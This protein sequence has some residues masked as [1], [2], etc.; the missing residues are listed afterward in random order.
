MPFPPMYVFAYG[1]PAV[2]EPPPHHLYRLNSSPRSSST[3]TKRPSWRGSQV[4][5]ATG[6]GGSTCLV[7]RRVYTGGQHL[8]HMHSQATLSEQSLPMQCSTTGRGAVN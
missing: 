4:A 1:Y 7:T 5:P 6:G 8:G 3:S 2:F